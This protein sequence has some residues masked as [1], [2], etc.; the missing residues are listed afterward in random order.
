M[1]YALG[2]LLPMP[3]YGAPMTLLQELY[4]A[5]SSRRR[6]VAGDL[7]EAF[8]AW[9]AGHGATV[10]AVATSREGARRLYEAKGFITR[11]TS[12]YWKMLT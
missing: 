3:L 12:C 10:A 2:G 1:G 8:T 9:T 4:V 6:G 11:P 7:I 5:E